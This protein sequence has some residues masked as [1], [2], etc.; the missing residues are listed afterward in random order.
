MAIS[1]GD[2]TSK[3]VNFHDVH[4]KWNFHEFHEIS[5]FSSKRTF[6]PKVHF[7]P[8]GL[9]KPS[10]YAVLWKD[11]RLGPEMC[12]FR[13]KSHFLLFFTLFAKITF[14]DFHDFHEISMFCDE[15]YGNYATFMFSF[16]ISHDFGPPRPD[17]RKPLKHNA[18]LMILEP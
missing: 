14:H 7:G 13:E 3:I 17:G 18:F 2:F 15:L 10:I 12:A 6:C 5:S 9:P 16:P 8:F 1:G 4:E 11:F